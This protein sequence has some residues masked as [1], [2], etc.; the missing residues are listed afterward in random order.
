MR[1]LKRHDKVCLT[2]KK[3]Y[4]SQRTDSKYCSASCKAIA[5]NARKGIE[6]VIAE[7]KIQWVEELKSKYDNVPVSSQYKKL[8]YQLAEIR[9]KGEQWIEMTINN[10]K[11]FLIDDAHHG[12]TESIAIEDIKE[13]IIIYKNIGVNAPKIK[14]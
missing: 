13:L 5:G 9:G 10:H 1:S 4:Q 6:G 8:V 7:A 14:H 11:A 3:E 2:C 12:Y